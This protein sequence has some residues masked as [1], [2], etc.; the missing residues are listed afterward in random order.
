MAVPAMTILISEM[1]DTIIAAFQRM[2]NLAVEW[3]VLPRWLGQTRDLL[4]RVPPILNFLQLPDEAG[5]SG[6]G[7]REPII[8]LHEAIWRTED[9]EFNMRRKE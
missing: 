5:S 3:T 6:S 9:G 7:I 8:R 2:T 4:V 1:S